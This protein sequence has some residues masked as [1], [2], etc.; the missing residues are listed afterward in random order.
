MTQTSCLSLKKNAP[1]AE[2]SITDANLH[3][4]SHIVCTLFTWYH[5][6][7]ARSTTPVTW[8]PRAPDPWPAPPHPAF[9]APRVA[10]W[11]TSGCP[12]QGAR[13]EPVHTPHSPALPTPSLPKACV[14][15]TH[16]KAPESPWCPASVPGRPPRGP[17]PCRATHSAS[18][19]MV[20]ARPPD[21]PP[22]LSGSGLTP[23][24]YFCS[25]HLSRLR[26]HTQLAV[27][28]PQIADCGL[29]QL[30]PLR[31]EG[32]RSRSRATATAPPSRDHRAF[33]RLY[34]RT[35]GAHPETQR[36][37]CHPRGG[38]ELDETNVVTCACLFQ[39]LPYSPPCRG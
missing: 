31:Q 16:E 15:K 23:S 26:G 36:V 5:L 38:R 30:G 21:L 37:A 10:G 28:R 6:G 22:G 35:Q 11:E 12:L 39:G 4:I 29:G 27:P 8:W 32:S 24:P 34:G 1:G 2:S 7:S 9:F 17:A 13:K 19:C 25:L 33:P 20:I 14:L 18:F 3:I